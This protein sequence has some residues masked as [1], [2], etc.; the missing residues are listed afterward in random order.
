[1]DITMHLSKHKKARLKINCFNSVMVLH[2]AVEEVACGADVVVVGAAYTEE[3]SVEVDMAYEVVLVVPCGHKNVEV[4]AHSTAKDT[5]LPDNMG[6][7]EVGSTVERADSAHLYYYPL[8][9]EMA[10]QPPSSV[11]PSMGS[12]PSPVC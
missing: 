5:A 1:M 10:Q 12:A 4:V 8:L 7:A 11:G 2:S 3:H 6:V 9:P